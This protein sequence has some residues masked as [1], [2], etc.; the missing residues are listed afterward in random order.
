M[1]VLSPTISKLYTPP[2]CTLE[3]T[4]KASPLSRWTRTP[5][6]Q[7]L[8][9]LL[10]FDRPGQ[11]T[12]E[13]VEIYGDRAQLAAL[14]ETVTQ[15]LQ[16][17][18]ASRSTDLPLTSPSGEPLPLPTLTTAANPNAVVLR[19]YSLLTHELRL[20]NLATPESGP[21]VMLKAS[22]LYDLA[23]ALEDC[24]ADM[25]H[26]PSLIAAERPS[27]MPWLRSAA[28]LLITVGIGT[29]T[30]RLFQ[31]GPVAVRPSA[32]RSETAMA[33]AVTPSPP[34]PSPLPSMPS[35]PLNLPSIQLPTRSTTPLG[36]ERAVKENQKLAETPPSN[37]KLSG[38][39]NSVAKTQPPQSVASLPSVELQQ[40]APDAAGQQADRAL[41][42][43]NMARS[44]S[45][46]MFE[47]APAPISK[48]APQQMLFDTIPQVAEVRDY[49]A[50]RWQPASPPPKTLEYRVTLNG[51]GSL[52]KVEPLGVSAQKYLDRVPLPKGTSAFVS[53]TA[54][55]TRPSVRLLLRQD[56]TVQTFLDSRGQ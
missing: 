3:V 37:K 2:T 20:G 41:S 28:I 7:S 9:F 8:Q 32:P 15:Y 22:Q 13:P 4:A 53:P 35:K 49:V 16:A 33:P 12:R 39:A 18:L 52:E 38:S 34:A 44:K 45:P 21:S 48:T 23:T 51:D 5:A 56:G 24:S 46:S 47:A 50:T 25:E 55:G 14:T 54:A 1:P 40:S 30:W 11:R 6:I 31:T 17:F 42:S 26:M 43:G 19:P 27:V 10:S 29:A 36:I